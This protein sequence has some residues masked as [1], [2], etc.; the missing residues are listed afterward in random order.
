MVI[1]KFQKPYII[2]EIGSS[3][4]GNI[5]LAK[6]T[7]SQAKKGG[8]DCVKFQLYDEKTIVHPKLKTL[9]YI[10]HNN[11][12]FQKDRFAKMKISLKE[13]DKLYKYAKKIK[14]DFCVTPFD[15]RFVKQINKYV[16]FF[17]VASGDLNFYP[18]LRE[19]KKTKK[20]ALI[21]TGMSSYDDIRNSLKYLDKKRTIIM[22]CVSSY[23]TNKKDINLSNIKHLKEFFGLPV[24]FSDHTT[25]INATVASIFFGARVIEKHFIPTKGSEKSADFP[26]SVDYK[27]LSQIRRK[28]DEAYNMI[29]KKKDGVLNCE[30]YG[31]KN[32]KRSIY[33]CKEIKKGERLSRNNLICLRPFIKKGVRIENFY[34]LQNKKALR[35]I[36]KFNL[37]EKKHIKS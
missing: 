27:K 12:K 35:N 1:K 30:K 4:L 18:L 15:P 36:K 5:K 3:H 22:H 19:I 32:L 33:A 2:A 17:K 21:S 34:K 11:F 28:I 9:S 26:L 24:G 31:E 25:G 8:A 23:P 16:K 13:L 20:L 7:I 29:G 10:K 37:V 6:K 14:L